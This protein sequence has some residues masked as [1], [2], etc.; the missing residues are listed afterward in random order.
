M[1]WVWNPANRCDRL[2]SECSPPAQTHHSE[3]TAA[4]LTLVGRQAEWQQLQEAW[5]L[6]MNGD[7]HFALITGEAGIGKSR[8]AEE[9][10]NWVN[11][12]GFTA[13]HTRSYAAEGRLSLAPVIEWL[14]SPILAPTFENSG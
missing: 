10:F 8:L 4:P 2:T 9:L 7:A 13:A 11:Q 1:N 3:R 12:Q 14:R 6:A 5:Q